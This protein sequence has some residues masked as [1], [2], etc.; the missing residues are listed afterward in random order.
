MSAE[1]R[2]RN[3]T[4]RFVEQV[5][6]LFE[7]NGVPRMAGRIIGW[8]L[9]CDPP[10]QSMAELVEALQASKSSISSMSRL[11]IQLGLVERVSLPG[12]R[13]D[14]FH[15]AAGVWRSTLR[16]GLA[17]LTAFRELAERGLKLIEDQSPEQQRRLEEMRDLYAFFEREYPVMLARW[18]QESQKGHA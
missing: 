1:D 8:L 13:R 17:Q 6:L 7:Q 9:V 10:H 4:R 16:S 5:G 12:Q 2:R 18:E 14:Y 11:L 15:I 3:E